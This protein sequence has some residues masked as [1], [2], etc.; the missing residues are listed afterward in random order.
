LTIH[1]KLTEDIKVKQ[2]ELI[3][4]SFKIRRVSNF[5]LLIDIG[6]C[7]TLAFNF[8]SVEKMNE[9]KEKKGFSYAHA[10]LTD[11]GKI[12][13]DE[14][15]EIKNYPQNEIWYCADFCKTQF[16][17][18]LVEYIWVAG[19]IRTV[20]SHC[21]KAEVNDESDYYHSGILGDVEK[22]IEKNTAII[23]SITGQ[24]EKAGFDVIKKC[25]QCKKEIKDL[26]IFSKGECLTCHE[27][28]FK[29]PTADEV[30]KSFINSLNK[31]NE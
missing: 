7:E 4:I 18:S 30:K 12:K 26:D 24:L 25:T 31:K 3:G 15:Y 22:A 27:K 8:Q 29:M 17:E 11:D 19:L 6:N 23:D 9:E 1:K 16:S 21:V 10:V 28:D 13:L 14:G 5:E 20:A 2:A